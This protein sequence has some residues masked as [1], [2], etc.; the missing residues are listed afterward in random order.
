VE[1]RFFGAAPAAGD[2]VA[3]QIR[4]R[5]SAAPARVVRVEDDA[6]DVAFDTPQ[7][8]VAPGQSAV[9]YAGDEV[10]GGGVIESAERVT[11]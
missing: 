1:A 7:V 8:A 2:A 10:V 9:L 3:V 4:S 11:G 6:F 5:H